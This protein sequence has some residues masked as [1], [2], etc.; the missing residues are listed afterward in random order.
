[1]GPRTPLGTFD[2]VVLLC[3]NKE[4]AGGKGGEEKRKAAV[5]RDLLCRQQ[6]LDPGAGISHSPEW[7]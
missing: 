7:R 6:S 5:A 2:P 1:M 3:L 4:A